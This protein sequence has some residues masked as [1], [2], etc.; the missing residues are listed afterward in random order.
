M[1][2][3]VCAE[4]VSLV[5]VS[6][7]GSKNLLCIISGEGNVERAKDYCNRLLECEGNLFNG[8]TLRVIEVALNTYVDT[9]AWLRYK[10]THNRR[11]HLN[12][13]YFNL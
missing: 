12:V 8:C 1:E 4:L 7:K 9:A 3:K 6:S 13:E 2:K 11:E 5:Y 10:A